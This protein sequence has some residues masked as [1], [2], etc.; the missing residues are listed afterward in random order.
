MNAPPPVN[1]IA[2][3]QA[4]DKHYRGVTAVSGVSLSLE[5]GQVTALVG[6]NGAGKTTLIKLLLG[7]IR[8]D[9]GRVLIG[10]IDPAGARGAQARRS[11]GFL[12]E[13]VAFHGAMT[14]HELMA[15][16]A[17]LKGQPVGR[18]AE[19]LERVGIAAAAHRRVATYSK[20]MRQRLGIAQ[21]LIGTPRLLLFD[22]PTSGLDP[23]S[24]HDVYEM[25]GTLR[26]TG[27]TVL[28]STHAL[29]EV[30]Q[31]VDRVAV[32]HGGRLLAAGTLAELR[33][34][35][36]AEV[37]IGLKVQPCTTA[38]VLAALPE[39]VRC[40]ERSDAALT[41]HVAPAGK[42]QALRAIAGLGE[43][44]HD[45]EL[46]V[47]GL[48]ELYA[49]LVAASASPALSSSASPSTSERAP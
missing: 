40:T 19:L 22:E 23:A 13:S 20:G 4:V 15:F 36:E 41:L 6:H 47:P 24:R 44:V 2:R 3:W 18:N 28:V 37:R 29:A 27:A 30:E 8:P 1:S 16:Y 31:R 11:I 7:L 45:V 33:Q 42:M 49:Q 25:I 35:A 21:A 46:V 38:R 48:Q 14:G 10:D 9:A 26:G 32:M 12:P 17:R 39:G 34:G 43:L 5:A